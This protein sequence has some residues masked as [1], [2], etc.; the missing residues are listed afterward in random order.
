MPWVPAPEEASRTPCPLHSRGPLAPPAALPPG[1]P[2]VPAGP[3]TWAARLDHPPEPRRGPRTLPSSQARST[4]GFLLRCWFGCLCGTFPRKLPSRIPQG[5]RVKGL[6][7]GEA[8]CG[9]GGAWMEVSGHRCGAG[10]GRGPEP[11]PEPAPCCP[12]PTRSHSFALKHFRMES[13][14]AWERIKVCLPFHAKFLKIAFLPASPPTPSSQ[15]PMRDTHPF[16]ESLEWM[17]SL[18]KT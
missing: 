18:T 6:A 12:G 17:V 9:R 3:Q 10:M 1:S 11:T 4:C 13:G 7:P 8:A 15:N 5:G 14:R 2:T 16:K